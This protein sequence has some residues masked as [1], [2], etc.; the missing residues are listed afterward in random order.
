[1]TLKIL[2]GCLHTTSNDFGKLFCCLHKQVNNF[3]KISGCLDK[4]EN[5]AKI[6]CSLQKHANDFVDYFVWDKDLKRSS[7]RNQRWHKAG[8]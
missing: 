8:S 7:S 1:V 4:L 6:I 3:I 5:F 2:F